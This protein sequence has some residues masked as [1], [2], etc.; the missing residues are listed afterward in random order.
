[1]N[2][3]LKSLVVGGLGLMMLPGMVK[4]EA[5][6]IT[7]LDS[8]GSDFRTATINGIKESV[9]SVSINWGELKYNYV[10]SEGSYVWEAENDSNYIMINL[11]EGELNA[12]LSW[13][14]AINGVEVKDY[15]VQVNTAPVGC[16]LIEYNGTVAENG[17]IVYSD[18]TCSTQLE[19]GASYTAGNAYYYN[20]DRDAQEGTS[21]II[22][23]REDWSATWIIDLVGGTKSDVQNALDGD[24]T[25][26]TF[27]VT[28][29]EYIPLGDLG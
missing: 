26:G 15:N 6:D 29:S 14:P 4:A 25:I 17:E 5:E 1:M 19:V 13:N 24:K 18:N 2:K 9:I 16:S 3:I 28:L 11:D 21:D 8:L 12:T 10:N 23:L 7:S 27:T 22:N 20:Y